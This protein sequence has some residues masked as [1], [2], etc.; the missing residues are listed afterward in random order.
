MKTPQPIIIDPKIVATIRVRVGLIKVNRMKQF[1]RDAMC[2][3]F[4][5]A[6]I[7]RK[8]ANRWGS[9]ELPSTKVCLVWSRMSSHKSARFRISPGRAGVELSVPSETCARQVT[10]F[11]L[12]VEAGDPH[13][14]TIKVLCQGPDRF[15][16]RLGIFRYPSPVGDGL[17]ADKSQDDHRDAPQGLRL[18]SQWV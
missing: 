4:N 10:R 2:Y 5:K 6:E 16:N 13:G 9:A 12:R 1:P 3:R 17:I 7:L 8:I 14:F 11:V 18:L 15:V